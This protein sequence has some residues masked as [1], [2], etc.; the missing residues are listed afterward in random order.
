M[1]TLLNNRGDFMKNKIC[2]RC[3]QPILKSGLNDPYLCRE[4]EKIVAKN[5]EEKFACIDN[6]G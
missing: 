6:R 5:P 2:T 1:I 3:C 4:C